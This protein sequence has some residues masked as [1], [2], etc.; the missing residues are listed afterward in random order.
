MRARGL[1]L[2]MALRCRVRFEVIGTRPARGLT[3]RYVYPAETPER[4]T[5]LGGREAEASGGQDKLRR[6]ATL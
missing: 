5:P 2:R 1:E 6:R 3:A 4:R